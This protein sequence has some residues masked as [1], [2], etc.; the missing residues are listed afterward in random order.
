M[1][2]LLIYVGEK[3][4]FDLEGAIQ[5]ILALAGTSNARRGTFIGSVF[6]CNYTFAGQTTIVRISDDL[7]TVTVEGID[8]DATD[9]AVRFQQRMGIAL[10]VIDMEYSFNFHLPDF[11]SGEELGRAIAG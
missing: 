6:E 3:Q 8:K 5:S 2:K 4:P 10:N 9:F 7:E 1:S 11:E